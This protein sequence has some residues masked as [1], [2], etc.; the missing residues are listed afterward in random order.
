MMEMQNSKFK[1]QNGR[2]KFKIPHGAGF[3]SFAFCILH[4][5]L[6]RKSSGFTLLETVVALALIVGA[7]IGPLTLASRGVFNAKFARSRILAINL[8][9]EGIELIRHMRENN[10]LREYHWR[11]ISGP[12]PSTCTKLA[13]G[14]YQ[15]DVFT[16]PGGSTP[17]P[18]SGS[19]L[20][21]DALT[22]LWS[23]STGAATPFTRVITLSTPAGDQM[24]VESL[25]T[26]EE[27]ELSRQVRLAEVLYNWQ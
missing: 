23:Q 13:D 10:V 1:I 25:V 26:W 14:S 12:C 20:R 3:R 9:Q 2:P 17:P 5:T 21:F 7:V 11:G 18:A 24:R 19:P 16:A 6:E 27:G 4:F 15:V 8:A 22:G